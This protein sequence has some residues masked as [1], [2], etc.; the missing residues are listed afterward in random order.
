MRRVDDRPSLAAPVATS[1]VQTCGSFMLLSEE[2]NRRFSPEQAFVRPSGDQL[3][4]LS[5]AEAAR[6]YDHGLVGEAHAGREQGHV[7]RTS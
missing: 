3:G 6:H 2:V 4:S 5:S 7:A 1:N